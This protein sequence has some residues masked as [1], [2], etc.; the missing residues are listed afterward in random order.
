MSETP[1]HELI[2]LSEIGTPYNGGPPPDRRPWTASRRRRAGG[3]VIAAA[4]LAALGA[5]VTRAAAGEEVGRDGGTVPTGTQHPGVA[6]SAVS[7]D[8]VNGARFDALFVQFVDRS[9]GFALTAACAGDEQ[10][11]SYGLAVSTDGGGSYQHRALPLAKIPPLEGYSAELHAVT[12][13]TVVIEDR[14]KWWVSVDAGRTWRSAP[15]SVARNTAGIPAAGRLHV[16]CVDATCES[17]ELTVIDPD[18]GMP[19]KVPDVPLRQVQNSSGSTIAPD[20]TRWVSGTTRSGDPALA[21]TRDG[22]RSWAVS[23]FPSP[24][25]L[26]FGPRLV[27]GPGQQR[28]AI[29]NVQREGAKNGFGPMY[30]STDAGRT[31]TRIRDGK[32]QPAS[33]LGAIVRPDGRLLIGTELDGS[34]ISTDKGRTFKKTE[35]GSGLSHFVE[36]GGM[37]TAMGLDGAHH[38]SLDGG[39]TWSP[40]SVPAP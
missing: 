20:G 35:T 6:S 17:R 32:G 18:S 4:L 39:V 21:V 23:R 28:Y 16:G 33:I 5:T 25:K 37:I 40:V 31:W 30:G 24:D 19:A 36:C 3:V 11:C 12:A 7:A 27:V 15:N 1:R 14:G 9:H 8:E 38:T 10:P 34:M 22:G 13:R 26:L 2:D 29:F